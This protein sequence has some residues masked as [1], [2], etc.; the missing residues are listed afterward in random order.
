MRSSK[1][2][3]SR[4]I[5]RLL[6][7]LLLIFIVLKIG[8]QS[9]LAELRS[10]NWTVVGLA[11]VLCAA[12]FA[13]KALRWRYILSARGVRVGAMKAARA[14]GAGAL[15]GILT[16]GR[17]GELT[18]A[19]FVPQWEPRASW[20]T[21]L[22]SV[23][24][25][26]IVDIAAFAFVALLG[27]VVVVAPR[28]WR[29]TAEFSALM[30]L[31]L[32]LGLSAFAWGQ[33]SRSRAGERFKQMMRSK[34][35]DAGHDFFRALKTGIGAESVPVAAWTVV[36][37]AL[38]FL[39]FVLLCRAVGS[40]L[41]ARVICWG[42]SLASL[43]AILPVSISGIGVRDFVLIAVFTAWGDTAART[44]AISLTYLGILYVSIVSVG[45]WPFMTGELDLS[46]LRR[47][48]PGESADATGAGGGP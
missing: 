30:L 25:D 31:V 2:N 9:L 15:V 46:L 28:A 42:I 21:A 32:G 33:L 8:R 14:Y 7:V 18:R 47:R 39:H 44:L 29:F 37:Y 22:G 43:A 24:L 26:R 12:H 48:G 5:L 40:G 35:G 17:V 10:A 34:F 4:R 16:P 20:G 19:A 1:P 3:W 6:G 13:A 38:F 23:V 27:G 36:S 45:I 41:S 11:A